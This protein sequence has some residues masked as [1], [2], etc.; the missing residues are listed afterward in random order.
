LFL[1]NAIRSAVFKVPQPGLDLVAVV[2]IKRPQRS[3]NSLDVN[4]LFHAA[5]YSDCDP[6]PEKDHFTSYRRHREDEIQPK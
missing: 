2:L 3:L 5:I 1:E 4:D 6:E